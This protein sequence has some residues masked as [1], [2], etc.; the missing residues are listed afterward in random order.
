MA[1][2]SCYP[3]DFGL[4]F[5]AK[6]ASVAEQHDTDGSDRVV[7]MRK[8]TRILVSKRLTVRLSA[9]SKEAIGVTA[10]TPCMFHFHETGI[11]RNARPTYRYLLRTLDF[12]QSAKQ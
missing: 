10:R 9:D 1:G 7:L 12:V 8:M 3:I 2:R 5:V 11:D 6:Q 4:V